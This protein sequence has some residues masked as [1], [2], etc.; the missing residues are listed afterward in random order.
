MTLPKILILVLAF[1]FMFLG[2]V[3]AVIV[4]ACVGGFLVTY[5]WME[6]QR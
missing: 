4:G 3:A 6:K 2:A 5:D 1:P